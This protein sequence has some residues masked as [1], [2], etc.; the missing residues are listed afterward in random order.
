[1]S[2]D[3]RALLNAI[4]ASPDAD[5][6]RL[7]YADWLEESGFPEKAAVMR[8]P[9]WRSGGGQYPSQQPFELRPDLHPRLVYLTG[10]SPGV[11]DC[12][13]YGVVFLMAWWSGPAR[14]AFGALARALCDYDPDNQ[15]LLV[16]VDV[17][18]IESELEGWAEVLEPSYPISGAGETLWI[19]LGRVCSIT[20]CG[21]RSQDH[22]EVI[23]FLLRRREH[24]A[25]TA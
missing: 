15:L 8:C 2:G 4:A 9:H 11:I 21:P 3:E 25:A 1:M 5:T 19:D 16:V 12:V 18:G 10:A 24:D 6:P 13:R 17:D 14:Q 20:A 7:V 22:A 23:R